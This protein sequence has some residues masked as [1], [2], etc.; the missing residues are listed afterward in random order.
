MTSRA[1]GG[2]RHARL[3]VL[4]GLML[5]LV[6]GC[7]STEPLPTY[8]WAGP[9]HALEVLAERAR[10]VDGVAAR[11]TITVEA[12]E[13]G[14]VTIDGLLVAQKPGQ[15][16]L[17]TWKFDRQIFDLVIRGEDMWL[18]TSG[19]AEELDRHLPKTTGADFWLNPLLEPLD[20]TTA[21]VVEDDAR[22]GRLTLSWA[23][24]APQGD[25]ANKGAET[26][27]MLVEVDRATLTIREVRVLD[28]SRNAV[29]S[30]RLERYRLVQDVP[31]PTRLIAS[32]QFDMQLRMDDVELNP[33]LPPTAFVPR[34]DARKR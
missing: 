5:L 4:V 20:P 7:R 19:E 14:P 1:V 12:P 34:A 6:A 21:T 30:V 25:E 13:R 33:D 23:L 8:D 9:A 11:C 17:Q 28:A 27:S 31:W 3:S 26:W 29:Q 2:R 16:R 24:A 22:S 18:W 15:M 32:G 10:Q